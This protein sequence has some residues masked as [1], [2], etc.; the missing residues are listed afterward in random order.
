SEQ[1]AANPATPAAQHPFFAR[2]T[3]GLAL[4]RQAYHANPVPTLAQ[5]LAD[6]DALKALIRDNEAALVAAVNADYGSRCRFETRFSEILMVLEDIARTKKQLK[7]WLKPQRRH[8]DRLLFPTSS[9]TVMP[10]PLGVIG[11]IVPWN[12][13]IML[14]LA[15]LVAIF[16]A[17]N[18]AMVKMSENSGQLAQLL[19]KLA[20]KYLPAD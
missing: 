11:V 12:F 10:Q 4:Q 16:A 15:P 19:I 20:P 17:G 9:C 14:S 3:E 2:F 18:R 1:P 13:P 8:I 7:K 6:L 5:R